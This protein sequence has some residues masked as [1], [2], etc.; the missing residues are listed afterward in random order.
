METEEAVVQALQGDCLAAIA[1]ACATTY[2][3]DSDEPVS[4]LEAMESPDW[5]K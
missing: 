2:S 1:L 3:S 5:T 4:R